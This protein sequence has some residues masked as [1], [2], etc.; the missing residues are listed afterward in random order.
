MQFPMYI[1]V[2]WKIMSCHVVK[3][4]CH[5][6]RGQSGIGG[7]EFIWTHSEKCGHSDAW[8]GGTRS[9]LMWDENG[10]KETWERSFWPPPR[11]NQHVLLRCRRHKCQNTEDDNL[12]YHWREYTNTYMT[13]T[14]CLTLQGYRLTL[15][16]YLLT[17]QRYRLTL[18]WCRLT[19]Q[20]YHLTLRWCWGLNSTAAHEW[21]LNSNSLAIHTVRHRG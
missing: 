2:L 18:Q 5:H 4:S 13:L 8:E 19:L 17:L 9:R 21:W 14:D 3:N 16:R 20:G 6:V 7:G 10:E 11:W 1:A 12:N 15:Q